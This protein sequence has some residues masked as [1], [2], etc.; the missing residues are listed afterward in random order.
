MESHHPS[1]QSSMQLRR[2]LLVVLVLLVALFFRTY[3]L[4]RVPPGVDGDEMFNGWDAHRV[5]KGTLAVY[6]P[7]NFGREPILIYLIALATRLLGTSAWTLRL[8][9]VLCGV[10]GLAF[11]WALARRL[12]NARVAILATALISISL[13]PIR[14]DRVALRAGLQAVFQAAA[15]YALW[16]TLND[17]SNR[18]S[19]AAGLL[20]GLTLYTYTASRVFPVVLI[21][22]LLMNLVVNRRLMRANGKRLALIGAVAGLVLLPLGLFALRHPG[23][24]NNRVRELNYE[25]HHLRQGDLDP[26]W[27][28]VKAAMGMFTQ[29]GDVKWRYNPSGRPVFDKVTGGLFYLGLIISLF[30]ARRPA[31]LLL[32]IWLPIMLAPTV[33]STGTPS[34]WRSVGALTPIYLLP[35]IGAD[36]VWE[37]VVRWSRGLGRRGPITRVALPLIV[38]LGMILVGADTWH[39]YFGVWAR[40]PEILDTFEADLAAAARYLDGYTPADTPVWVSSDYPSDLSR[41]LLQFQSTYPGPVRWFNGNRVTVWPSGWAGRDV[42]IIFTRTCPP[43]PDALAILNGYLIHHE[44]DAADRPHLWVYR[45]PGEALYETPWQP[46]RA[47]SGRFAYDREILG[48]DA[49]AQV[50]RQ[51]EVPIV[52]Y[53][54]VPP[55]IRYENADLPFS[56]ACLQDGVADRCAEQSSHYMVYP[57]WDWTVG[58]MVAQRYTV[59]VPAYLPPQTTH[60]RIGMFTSVGEIS[61]AGENRA[62]APLLIGPVEVVGEASIEPQ[63]N[64]DTPTFNQ[65]LALVG[66]HVPTDRPPGSTLDAELHW[67]AMRP[68]S[69]AYVLRLELRAHATG[70]I[71][72][73]ARELLGSERHPTSRWI[74]GEPVHTFHAMQIPPDLGG[75]FDVYL[76]LLEGADQQTIAAPLF[77]GTLSISGRAHYFDLPSPEHPLVADFGSSI[78]LLGFDLEQIDPTPGGQIQIVLYWQTL[79]TVSTDYKVFVHLYHPTDDWISGQH[80]S[81]PGDG[82]FPTSGWLP[83]EIVTDLHLIAV[84]PDAAAGVSAT[85]IGL[86]DPSTGERLPVLV[87]GQLQPDNRLIITEVEIR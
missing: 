18:W 34:F 17:R 62:G 36:F 42:L 20:T 67:Q 63:W 38:V 30:R 87:D 52:V 44:N 13:W 46:T 29:V 2:N 47:L 76:V 75:E 81:Q 83:G 84:E 60:F 8:P 32:L 48:C 55:D 79:D 64:A 41:V 9:M 77:L 7:A 12:F 14:L 33:L 35:A 73:S 68:P 25:L 10:V 74:S 54:R 50:Q 23:T 3:H 65:D 26:L 16:R 85:G 11:T 61:F 57:V 15:A 59:T 72:A 70:A 53:W 86:Y 45:I 28:S 27:H 37:R 22:W 69:S 40:H 82:A 39:D 56:F 5:W 6:F 4:D 78:R 24:L 43:N 71:A 1:N 31:Y 58:D 51:T 19:I 66:Y 80:D 21:L 49:P